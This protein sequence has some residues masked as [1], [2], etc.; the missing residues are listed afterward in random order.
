MKEIIETLE[1]VTELV[2][3][4]EREIQRLRAE[5]AA[6]KARADFF[7]HSAECHG[8]GVER[9]AM[10]DAWKAAEKARGE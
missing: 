4:G 9:T 8:G 7:Q 2:A 3:K 5:L 6:E 1:M 10:Y